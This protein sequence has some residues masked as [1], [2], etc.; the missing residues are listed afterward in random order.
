[1][2]FNH[3][4]EEFDNLVLF[5]TSHEVFVPDQM[6]FLGFAWDHNSAHLIWFEDT[7]M[8]HSR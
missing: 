8:V 6:S 4:D 1:M 2:R 5:I 7:F 3:G